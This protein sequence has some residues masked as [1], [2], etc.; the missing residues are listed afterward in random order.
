MKF[1]ANGKLIVWDNKKQ[2]ELCR[3]EDGKFETDDSYIIKELIE[4]NYEH[5][6]EGANRDYSEL[7]VRE[8]L[9]IA[10]AKGIEGYS[11][12]NKEELLK[13]INKEGD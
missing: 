9:K 10:K 5:D 11:R 7:G 1:Y 6:V 4:L 8:L 12:K 3:F 2:K 13:M